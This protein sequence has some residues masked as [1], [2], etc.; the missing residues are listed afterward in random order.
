MILKERMSVMKA[1]TPEVMQQAENY[2]FESKSAE[3]LELMK[4]AASGMYEEIA[5]I[6]KRFDIIVVLCGKG[7]NAGDGYELARILRAR[8]FN[9]LCISVFGVHPATD[10]AE[11][12]YNEYLAEG[13]RVETDFKAALRAIKSADIIIDAV[14]GIG[15]RGVIEEES[16]IYKLIDEANLARGYRIALDVPSGIRS[17]DGSV[18]NIAFAANETLTV[19]DYKI[20]MLSYPAKV[21][22]G[23]VSKIDIGI[24][25]ELLDRFEKYHIIPDDKYVSEKLPKRP[26][27]SNKG[28]FG[29]L[30][31]V[32]GSE[33]MTGAAVLSVQAALRAGTGLVTLASEKSVC[34]CVKMQLSEP[35]YKVLDFENI[36]KSEF[37]LELHKSTAVLIGCGLGKTDEKKTLLEDIIRNA[38]G[39]I[40]IDADGI[41]MLCDNI[42]ILREAKR[43]P[44]LTPHPGE[45]ARLSNL[46]VTYINDNRIKCALEFSAK[47]KCITV[48]KGAGTITAHPDGRYAVNIS[49]NSGL[50]KGGSGDVLAGLIAGLS[51]N[52]WIDPF[53][54]AC[55]GV[56]LH[57]RAADVLKE[58]YSEYGYL[59][60]ELA[61]E[62]AKM[63]P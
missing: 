60:S 19:S 26:E 3:P 13:G 5:H 7:N 58:K 9:T 10:T 62:F 44:I 57:G 43:I 4:K 31:C 55:C 8:G 51:A 14:F 48:L 35:I 22:C 29:R 40:V 46:D 38:P 17:G 54:A 12:C 32:C 63:L 18:G 52:V 15:F 37:L 47:Y 34:D 56:Y 42:N 16:V 50:A 21:F 33:N 59:P 25:C 30:L 27:M 6:L 24:P 45:F 2:L 53:D 61:G 1:Y 11:I 36:N 41:N 28:D 49:G 20:G 39:Q 23:R